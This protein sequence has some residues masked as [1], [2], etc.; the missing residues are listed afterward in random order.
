MYLLCCDFNLPDI[1][2]IDASVTGHQN[3]LAVNRG[4]LEA[5]DDI[6][7]TQIV[8]FPTH[9]NPDHTLDLILTNRPSLIQRSEPLSGVADDDAV[10]AITKLASPLHKP[11]RRKIHLWKKANM[12]VVRQ[13]I[14]TYSTIFHEQYTSDTPVQE[15]WSAFSS[16]VG[17]YTIS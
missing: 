17:P 3:Q 11:I 15:M 5:F 16:E 7:I 1:H 6:G 2:W 14:T 9:S 13:S 12:E 8:D 4:F 10:L